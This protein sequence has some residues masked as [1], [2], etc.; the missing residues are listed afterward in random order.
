MV[1]RSCNGTCGTFAELAEMMTTCSCS[2][3]LWSLL[4]RSASGTVSLPGWGNTAMPGTRGRGLARMSSTKSRSGPSLAPRLAVTIWRPRRQVVISANTTA[5][6]S[7][8]NQP[9]CSTLLRLAA[10]KVSSMPPNT[11]AARASFHGCQFHRTRATISIR[12]VSTTRAPVTDTP[13]AVASFSEDRNA[14][15]STMTPT[16]STAFTPGR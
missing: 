5:A 10:R 4:A 7:S 14:T 9:P 3:W 2:T 11:T 13:Y 8:G 1:S 16:N 6:M 12:M 15:I